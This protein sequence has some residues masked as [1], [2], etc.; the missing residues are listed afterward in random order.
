MNRMLGQASP[1]DPL[2]PGDSPHSPLGSISVSARRF[3]AD[4]ADQAPFRLDLFRSL[5]LHRRMALGIA[6][7]FV[8]LALAYL[9]IAWPTY[10]PLHTARLIALRNTALIVFIG[11]AF[12]ALAAV[13]A[14]KMEPKVYIPSEV[15]TAPAVPENYAAP[16]K[17]S[18][19]EP[20]GPYVALPSQLFARELPPVPAEPDALPYPQLIRA[21]FRD[22]E[23][24][25]PVA[26]L[27]SDPQ[28]Q[29]DADM[30]WWLSDASRPVVS[31]PEI[32]TYVQ[33]TRVIARQAPAAYRPA[34]LT[35]GPQPRAFETQLPEPKA[36]EPQYTEPQSPE[37]Q[38][39]EYISSMSDP[40]ETLPYERDV[41]PV[42]LAHVAPV[43]PA[44]GPPDP[45]SATRAFASP[46]ARVEEVRQ[47]EPEDPAYDTASRLSGL[48]NL[49]STAGMK[50]LQQHKDS[51]PHHEKAPPQN[52]YEAEPPVYP[53][54]YV[55]APEPPP[56]APP[57]AP[58]PIVSYV[59]SAPPV[60]APVQPEFVPHA[61][62]V[63]SRELLSPR[64]GPT[65]R[66]DRRDSDDDIQTLPSWRGQYKKK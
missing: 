35:H 64:R 62:E 27:E 22:P 29:T 21:Y 12:A 41:A 57:P 49:F 30:P 36:P 63:E 17:P 15:E 59:E 52:G 5:Q 10:A 32:E 7:T 60:L 42:A 61:P 8:L 16:E 38:P 2:H 11:L 51:G 25:Q 4:S 34:P 40:F 47:S 3:G 33:P 44:P 14:R 26:E 24:I 54:F 65:P 66:R 13:I 37:P 43:H 39:W 45:V 28:S 9:I 6:L 50:N 31:E 58:A 20:A 19:L 23:P 18:T 48:R 53:Q 46:A 56:P 1:V 55:S